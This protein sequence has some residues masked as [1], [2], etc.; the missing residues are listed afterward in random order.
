MSHSKGRPRGGLFWFFSC[1]LEEQ[2]KRG[3]IP[4]TRDVL[5]GVS[6]KHLSTEIFDNVAVFPD[7]SVEVFLSVSYSARRVVEAG[8]GLRQ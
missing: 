3:S 1:W 4:R 8:R 7:R 5:L 6:S 2:P